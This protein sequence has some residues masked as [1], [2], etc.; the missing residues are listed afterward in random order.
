MTCHDLEHQVVKQL[1]RLVYEPFFRFIA[2]QV[3]SYQITRHKRL[4]IIGLQVRALPGAI[5]SESDLRCNDVIYQQ[6]YSAT[7]EPLLSG[8]AIIVLY[9]TVS[10]L[11]ETP[12]PRSGPDLACLDFFKI[13]GRTNEKRDLFSVV[14]GSIS[15]RNCLYRQADEARLHY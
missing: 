12:R 7:S 14:F 5:L 2:T 13:D 3:D 1:A 8:M 11:R 6:S 10:P 4:W 9:H 15:D